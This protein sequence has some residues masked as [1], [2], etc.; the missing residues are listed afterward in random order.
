MPDIYAQLRL[1]GTE[2]AVRADAETGHL[3]ELVGTTV[4]IL[5]RGERR[6][7]VRGPNPPFRPASTSPPQP[8]VIPAIGNDDAAGQ[9]R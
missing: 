1:P 9:P 2:L 7:T 5:L 4:C 8:D 3:V 6:A